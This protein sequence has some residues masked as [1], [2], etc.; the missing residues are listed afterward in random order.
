MFTLYFIIQLL[1]LSCLTLFFKRAK[2]GAI[3]GWRLQLL[4]NT[5]CHAYIVARYLYSVMLVFEKEFKS[6]LLSCVL[7]SQSFRYSILALQSN[8][9]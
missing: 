4:M 9:T 6:T 5:F 8:P 3:N 7:A 1:S 2:P